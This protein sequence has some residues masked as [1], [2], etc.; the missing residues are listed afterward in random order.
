MQ[1]LASLRLA[2]GLCVAT[3][4]ALGAYGTDAM[5]ETWRMATK[6][7]PDSPEGKVFQRF[8]DLVGQYSEGALTIQVFPNEQLGQAEAV[9]EQLSAGTVH[10]YT[11]DITYL[12]KWE[13]DVSWLGAPFV[14]GDRGHWLRFIGTDLAKGWLETARKASGISV[15]GELGR[16]VR[17]PYRVLLADK[18]IQGL[19]QV[20]GLKLRIWDNKLMVSVWQHLG[21]E[22]RVIGWSDVYQSLQSGV[23]DAATSPVAL[24]ESMK[25]YEVAPHIARTDEFFQAVA[26]MVN[27]AAYSGLE[28]AVREAVLRA[29]D[30]AGEY[31]A[32]IMSEVTEESLQRM[33]A[34]G[35][36]FNRLDP[37]P[38]V[39]RMKSF[40][41]ERQKSG[42]LPDGFFATVESTR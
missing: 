22:V 20:Q 5:A 42:E 19:D 14:F 12:E 29:Y 25:F 40:Y 35:S 27:D 6:E 7:T 24:V 2:A 41:E 21:A 15:I 18:E 37:A 13:P 33:Q 30:E 9:L 16:M 3:A 26:F 1:L 38:F 10:I 39:E 28:P 32:T 23:V 36:T 17:G 31:S 34:K 11:E 8:A 4:A